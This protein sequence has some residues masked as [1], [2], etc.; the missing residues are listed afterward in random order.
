MSKNTVFV[1]IITLFLVTSSTILAQEEQQ[2]SLLSLRRIEENLGINVR[3][4]SIG[5]GSDNPNTYSAVALPLQVNYAPGRYFTLAVRLNQGYQSLNE[6]GLYSLSNLDIR[7]R[8]LIGRR[9]TVM[10]GL[11]VPTGTTE[12]NHEQF[13]I[14]SVGKIPYINAPH[15]SAHSGFGYQAGFSVGD[16]ITENTVVAFGAAYFAKG[17][18][19]PIQSGVTYKPGDV[20]MLSLG[21]DSGS[22]DR[23]GFF[24]DAQLSVYSP[25][26]MAGEQINESGQGVAFSGDFYLNPVK[27]T[28]LYL[29]RA[30]S[31]LAYGGVF[32]APSV[33]QITLGYMISGGPFV[34]YLG[35]ELVSEG[36]QVSK[37]DLWLLG[38]SVEQFM[39]MNY[40]VS[41]FFQVRLGHV[42]HKANIIGLQAGTRFSFQIY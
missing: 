15:L 2:V 26:E 32:Q 5:P 42:N 23:L 22:R 3:F 36:T 37:A 21:L 20:F 31:E 11:T 30:K 8:Y 24:G 4:F 40:P 9:V 35:Y 14:S 41:P 19:V 39:L 28:A 7:A 13:T 6:N 38:F 1:T 33:S 29:Q 25:E 17:D 18:Y 34:P 12:L 16:Q 27:L 10:A